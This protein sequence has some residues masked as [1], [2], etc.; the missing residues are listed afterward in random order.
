MVRQDVP[1]QP[2][3]HYPTPN[4]LVI[5]SVEERIDGAILVGTT[6]N[7]PHHSISKAEEASVANTKYQDHCELSRP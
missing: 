4:G 6:I 2:I 3:S 5:N 7:P 1:L